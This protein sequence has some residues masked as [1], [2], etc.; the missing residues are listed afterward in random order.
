M[1]QNINVP[2]V[3]TALAEYLDTQIE[4]GRIDIPLDKGVGYCIGYHLNENIRILITAYQLNKEILIS[5][6]ELLS[7]DKIILFKFQGVLSDK[8]LEGKIKDIPHVLVTTSKIN[9]ENTIVID[10]DY[11][12]TIEIDAN[13]LQRQLGTKEHSPIIKGLL[14]DNQPLLFEE[15]ASPDLIITLKELMESRGYGTFE[16]FYL[17]IKV[18]QIVCNLLYQLEKRTNNYLYALNSQDIQAIYKIRALILSNLAEPPQLA[19]LVNDSNMSLSKLQRLFKQVFGQTVFNYYQE[20]R[21]KEAARLLKEEKLSVSEVG[22]C[23]GFTNLSHFSKTFEKYIGLKP[24]KY[25][26]L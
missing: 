14:E 5:N 2:R 26:M 1:K 21:I 3:F 9:T 25:T 18:E 16:L 6:P 17:K 11:S 8:T 22:Y 4:Y 12:V 20:F 10:N 7:N 23:L 19:A 13:Y 15:L 24:K